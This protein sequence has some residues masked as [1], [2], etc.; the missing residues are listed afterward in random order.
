MNISKEQVDL[1]VLDLLKLHL[2]EIEV[3]EEEFLDLLKGSLSLSLTEKKRVIDAVPELSQFQFDELKKVFLEE[4]EKFRELAQAHPE[5]I[6]K[7]LV[8]QQQEWIELGEVYLLEQEKNNTK[9]QDE[10]KI[11]DIK[12]SLGL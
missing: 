9:G 6:K 8:K 10:Q 7:L 2:E 5:D 11:D 12:K 3:D 4:R 1:L